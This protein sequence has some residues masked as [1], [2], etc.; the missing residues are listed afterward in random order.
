LNSYAEISTCFK[1][2][3]H[4]KTICLKR[5]RLRKFSP[6]LQ[7]RFGPAL[8]F[9]IRS[10]G[11]YFFLLTAVS[12][13]AIT[14][15]MVSQ[16]ELSTLAPVLIDKLVVVDPGHGGPDPGVVRYGLR[17]KDLTLAVASRLAQFLEQSGARVIMTRREDR[18]LADPDIRSLRARKQQDLQRRVA[19]ANRNKADAFIS[20]HVNSF[21]GA[22]EH[23]AQTFYNPDSPP[24]KELA[25]AIQ[26]EFRALLGTRRQSKAADYFT[27][28]K[29]CMPA[30]VVEIGFLSNPQESK[31][32]G[33]PDYQSKVAFAVYA[34]L[35][36]YFAVK[37]GVAIE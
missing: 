4:L 31:L 24:G 23:G 6:A 12:I 26:T 5:S 17:E 34:G 33:L 19:L 16:R 21:P 1:G 28:R 9:L 37:E 22:K 15:V 35:I 20:I 36:R 29:T 10:V 14:A 30:V 32:L 11:A 8:Q 7:R 13:Y 27:G 2:G 25:G 18:D 3:T